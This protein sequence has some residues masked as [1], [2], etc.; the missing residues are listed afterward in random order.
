MNASE[1]SRMRDAE[2]ENAQIDAG[3][4]SE[5]RSLVEDARTVGSR[6]NAFFYFETTEQHLI[7]PPLRNRRS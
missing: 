4:T 6:T 1:F 7:I 5:F 2:T 3:E